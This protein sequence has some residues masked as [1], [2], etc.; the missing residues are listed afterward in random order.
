MP[1]AAL[2][3]AS[4]DRPKLLEWNDATRRMESNASIEAGPSASAQLLM[5]ANQDE[6]FDQIR[7]RVGLLRQFG[8]RAFWLPA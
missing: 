3:S 6:V 7:A 8:V 1:L 5:L 2:H 4:R